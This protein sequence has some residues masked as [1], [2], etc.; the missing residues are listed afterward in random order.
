MDKITSIGLVAWQIVS[1]CTFA[2]LT[3][4]DGYPYTWWNWIIVV[5]INAF[6]SEIWPAYWL[7]LR[8]LFGH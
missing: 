3:F 8:P 7:I 4:F 5:P 2:F 1:A 6:L